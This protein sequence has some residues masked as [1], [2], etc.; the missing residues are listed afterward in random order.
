MAGRMGR[1]TAVAKREE[2]IEAI[3]DRHANGEALVD[4]C[5]EMNVRPAEFRSWMR[6]GTVELQAQWK[7]VKTEHAHSIFDQI[8]SLAHKLETGRFG[9]EDGARVQALR[10]AI[11]ALKHIASRLDPAD[12]GEQKP[13]AQGVVVIINTDLALSGKPETTIDGEFKIAVPLLENKNG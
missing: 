2:Q 5:A 1:P 10:G 3:F 6:K 11:D 4:I 7:L 12:Y 8:R 13:G 9:K